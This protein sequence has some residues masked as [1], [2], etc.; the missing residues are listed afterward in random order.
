MKWLKRRLTYHHLHPVQFSQSVGGVCVPLWLL[1][2]SDSSDYF[3]CCGC[4]LME[5]VGTVSVPQL[6]YESTLRKT[7]LRENEIHLNELKADQV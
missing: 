5:A 1:L 7:R 3:H 4:L 2:T 6:H